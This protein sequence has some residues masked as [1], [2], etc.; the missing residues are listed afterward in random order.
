MA[1]PLVWV[2]RCGL[3]NP[4]EETGAPPQGSAM[5]PTLRKSVPPPAKRGYEYRCE[6]KIKIGQEM[7]PEFLGTR[8]LE[9]LFHLAFALR[10]LG[11]DP[12]HVRHAIPEDRSFLGNHRVAIAPSVVNAGDGEDVEIAGNHLN[13]GGFLRYGT[14]V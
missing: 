10:P 13:H 2:A 9:V 6:N 1:P 4:P 5:I 8:Q 11:R 12:E 3:A 7:E 14:G